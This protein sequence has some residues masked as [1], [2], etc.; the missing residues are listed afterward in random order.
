[1]MT[2]PLSE[3]VRL[4]DH[5]RRVKSDELAMIPLPSVMSFAVFYTSSYPFSKREATLSPGLLARSS[6]QVF[7]PGLLTKSSHQVLEQIPITLE[8]RCSWLGRRASA[9][10]DAAAGYALG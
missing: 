8:R 5:V 3:M 6:H 1:M 10:F 7:S 2:N 9:I 4:S